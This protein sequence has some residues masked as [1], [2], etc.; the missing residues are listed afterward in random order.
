MAK[1]SELREI[2]GGMIINTKSKRQEK[3]LDRAVQRTAES[4]IEK[5]GP[6]RWQLYT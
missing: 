6:L 1:K 4:L 3:S 2:R 5:F